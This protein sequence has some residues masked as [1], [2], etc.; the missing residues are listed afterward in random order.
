MV[1]IDQLMFLANELLA[2][3]QQ[4]N[5]RVTKQTPQNACMIIQLRYCT[6][7]SLAA[8]KNLQAILLRKPI[9][10]SSVHF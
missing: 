8:T 7:C 10:L 2:Q 4:P 6:V 5:D 3:S 9:L 1:M